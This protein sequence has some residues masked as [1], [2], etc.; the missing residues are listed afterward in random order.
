MR[1]IRIKENKKYGDYDVLEVYDDDF[2]TV[3]SDWAE[4]GVPASAAEPGEQYLS[5]PDDSPIQS[6][7]SYDGAEYH[8]SLT[9]A[10]AKKGKLA[11]IAE[12]RYDAVNKNGL[13]IDGI[14]IDTDPEAR[15]AIQEAQMGY[16]ANG[17]LSAF[18]KGRNGLLPLTPAKFTELVTKVLLLKSVCFSKEF[19]LTSAVTAASTIEQVEA[20]EWA[21]PE[22]AIPA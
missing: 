18:W 15:I 17:T 10:R 8:E 5:I 1:V 9:L 21:T 14:I 22:V 19:E 16:A 20:I 13:V 6:G 3:R 11:E 7:W 4:N 2:C 12:K